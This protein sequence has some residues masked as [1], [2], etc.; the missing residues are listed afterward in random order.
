MTAVLVSPEGGSTLLAG[1]PAKGPGREVVPASRGFRLLGG[2]LQV[3]WGRL[4]IAYVLVTSENLLMLAQP[5]A[6]GQAINHL[7]RSS[8]RGLV[9]LVLLYLIYLL[10]SAARRMYDGRVFT[11]VY[12]DLATRLVLEQRRREIDVSR[13]VARSALSREFVQFFQV[14]LP[15]VLQAVYSLAGALAMLCYYDWTLMACCLALVAP[16]CAVNYFFT[17]KVLRLNVRL[18]DELEREVSVIMEGDPREV[19]RHYHGVSSWRIKLA[20]SEA[21]NYGVIE[22]FVIGLLAVGLL[23]SCALP[24]VAAGDILAVFR[25]VILFVTALDALPVLIQH[26]SRLC[27]IGR[28]MEG[29]ASDGLELSAS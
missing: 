29:D 23:R 13:V 28:R 5:W 7:L 2:L 16:V 27:D 11:R 24:G 19:S 10:V 21:F 1:K 17:R 26:V 9:V 25:Y 8:P 15:L 14:Y 4:L 6:L 3:C 12:A 22:L 20:D 18:H